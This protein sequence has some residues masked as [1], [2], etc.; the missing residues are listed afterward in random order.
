MNELSQI[1]GMN[2]YELKFKFID[3]DGSR[4]ISIIGNPWILHDNE[5][6]IFYMGDANENK[7]MEARNGI[8]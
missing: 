3:K 2:N 7:K 8:S 1:I 5:T 4:E 6:I